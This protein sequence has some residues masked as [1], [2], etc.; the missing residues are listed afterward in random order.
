MVAVADATFPVGNKCRPRHW[1]YAARAPRARCFSIE[2]FVDSRLHCVLRFAWHQN[3]AHISVVLQVAG[4]GVRVVEETL[5]TNPRRDTSPLHMRS[6]VT[7]RYF[8]R[9][10]GLNP[11]FIPSMP[12]A[13]FDVLGG[14]HEAA[15]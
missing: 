1:E 12:S 8:G 3:V 2:R 7:P 10:T 9:P 11:R 14:A 13:N 5:G 6:R 4:S 15:L